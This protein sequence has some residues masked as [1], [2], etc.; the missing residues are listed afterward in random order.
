MSIEQKQQQVE[1]TLRLAPVVPVVIIEDAR[2]AVPMARALV[3]GGIPAIEVT[4]RT[5]AALDAI[6]AIAE[7][8]EG[9]VVG[10]GTVLGAKDL[11]AAHKAGAR[12]AV[13]PGVSPG[14]LDA[15]D[16]S[17]LPLL[18][19]SATASEVMALLERGYRFLK[20]FPAVPAGGAR[21]LG[22]WA[23][24]LP[25]VMFC[26]TG[27]ISLASAPEFLALPN[28]VCVGGSWL[29]P[30][31]KLRGGDWAGIEQLAREAAALR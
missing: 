19:G 5:P 14:L 25:Q 9:A 21:L 24:P 8:V 10:A 22:A 3:A 1:S 6:K 12:F 26:P 31:D 23:S 18:P 4:L 16:D 11:R 30:A 20:F 15:A 13:S 2:A 28:V 7:E 29:T 17:E 27:G